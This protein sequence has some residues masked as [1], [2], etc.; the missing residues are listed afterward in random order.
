[1]L[2]A[3]V[4]ANLVMWTGAVAA[5]LDTAGVGALLAAAVTGLFGLL[6]TVLQA[7]I[8]LQARRNA[9]LAR[10]TKHE[11]TGARET[12]RE[13]VQVLR[14]AT[15]TEKRKTGRDRRRKKRGGRRRNDRD[16]A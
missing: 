6:N 8:L 16:G 4:L 10:E 13:S 2:P 14:E 12:A 5:I 7:K 11:V 1:M 9:E 15:G 3:A